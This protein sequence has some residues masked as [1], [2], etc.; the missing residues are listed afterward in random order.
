MVTFIV[1]AACLTERDQQIQVLY[2]ITIKF[3]VCLDLDVL[4]IFY[5]F[6]SVYVV[7]ACFISFF[8]FFGDAS[9]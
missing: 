4:Q 3:V 1:N 7:I 2:E 6:F 8:F 5:L 9:L